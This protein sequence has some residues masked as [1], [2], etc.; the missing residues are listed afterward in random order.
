MAF[1]LYGLRIRLL[2]FPLIIL[3]FIV[4]LPPFINRMLTFDLKLAASSL[5]VLMLRASGVSVFLEGN[6][7]DLGVSQMQVVDACSGLRYLMPLF[8]M[9]LLVGFFFSNGLWRRAILF[10]LAIPISVFLNSFRIWVTGILS[11]NGHA[12]L[13]ENLFHDFTGWLIFMVAGVLLYTATLLFNRI[14]SIR[15]DKSMKDVASHRSGIARPIVL[16]AITCLALVVSGWALKEIPSAR[17]LPQRTTFKYFPSSIS[18][19]QVK[20]SYISKKIRDQ[21]WA[22][23]YV[24]ATLANPVSENIIY[25][26]IPFYEYQGVRHAAHAPQACL[27]GGGW[28]L[29][30]SQKRLVRLDDGNQINIM[31]M[32]LEKGETKVLG[33]YFFLQRGRVITSPWM[34]KYYLLADSFTKGRTDGALVRAELVLVPGQTTDEAWFILERFIS[35]LW[36]ILPQYVPS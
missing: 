1:L 7:I 26:L 27:L 30:R 32:N 5:S 34:N 21:L 20:R 22:D 28:A 2:I 19:W 9:S 16:S 3:A 6:V 31:T 12:E 15:T 25:L 23:D 14:G 4:P 35:E 33:S 18:E 17:N 11:V 24:Q 13:A 8:I 29:T 36:K 10:I